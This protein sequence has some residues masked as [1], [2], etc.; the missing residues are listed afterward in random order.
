MEETIYVYVALMMKKIRINVIFVQGG[1]SCGMHNM[2]C[3]V[4]SNTNMK[5]PYKDP[6]K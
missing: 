4:A 1:V 2:K 3:V 6:E 5:E